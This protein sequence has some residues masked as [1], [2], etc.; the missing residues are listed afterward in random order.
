MVTRDDYVVNN[1]IPRQIEWKWQ[2]D[3]REMNCWRVNT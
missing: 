3:D 2:A 1:K